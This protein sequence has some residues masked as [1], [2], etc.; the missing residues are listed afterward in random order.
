[1][2][3][4]K[5]TSIHQA[6]NLARWADD[7]RL[8]RKDIAPLIAKIASLPIKKGVVSFG[9]HIAIDFDPA[10]SL[11][12]QDQIFQTALDLRPWRKGPFRLGD[13]S[14]DSEW[15][16]FKKYNL[17]APYLDIEGKDVA[18]VGCNNGYYLWRMLP[19]K[20][21]CLIGFDPYVLFFCQFA[22]LDHFI[23]SPIIYELL[24]IEHLPTYPQKFD[25]IL[26]LGVLYHR[27][28]PITSLKNLYRSLRPSGEVILDTLIL[29]VDEEI[30]LCPQKS[31]AKMSNA[32][33]IPSVGALEGWCQR[34]GFAEVECLAKVKTDH[35]E[36][37][38][39]SWIETMSLEDFLD[40]LDPNRTIEGYQAPLRGYF[41]LKRK[42]NG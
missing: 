28:D 20:P 34:A 32:Y 12:E 22:F 16:S 14:I 4:A 29:D 31:Y 21:S 26:C 6:S 5:Q 1:M 35:L 13:L 30:A 27:T 40:P 15:Q 36:Q 10:L 18:D 7:P 25:V 39:T 23:S 11:Q 9:D 42:G 2:S 33:F 38:K 41:R 3:E 24:G 19:L 8:R 17:I 37:R